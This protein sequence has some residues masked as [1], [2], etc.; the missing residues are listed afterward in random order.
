MM[1]TAVLGALFLGCLFTMPWYVVVVFA[2]ALIAFERWYVSSVIGVFFFDVLHSIPT[3]TLGGAG[4][5]LTLLV[6]GA[7]LLS[8]ILRQR[9]LE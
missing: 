9:L 8:F 4:Y 6:A 7:S 3:D 5:V 1:K 2:L